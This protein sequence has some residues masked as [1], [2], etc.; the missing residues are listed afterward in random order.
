[1]QELE[2]L[3]VKGIISPEE[4]YCEEFFEA[5]HERDGSGRYIVR[6]SA[7]EKMLPDLGE[8]HNGAMRIFL[9]TKQCLGCNKALRGTYVEFM[10]T[11]AELSHMEE[12]R[13]TNT[14]SNRICYLSHHAVV[15]KSN[16]EGKI[17]M[18][19]NVSF[20]TKDEFSLNESFVT[21]A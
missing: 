12:I 4:I 21:R 16:P 5:V 17:R 6:L 18:V 11:Y 14:K 8:S 13:E 19:Y 15:K 20:R 10:R 1:L 2:E 7:K 3:P 9:N